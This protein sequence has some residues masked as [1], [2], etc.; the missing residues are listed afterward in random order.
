MTRE[1]LISLLSKGQNG[2]Q[3]LEILDA[4]TVGNDDNTVSESVP[5]LNGPGF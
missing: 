2:E 4:L 1:V 5:Q 3:I